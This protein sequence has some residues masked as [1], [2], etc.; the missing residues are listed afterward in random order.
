MTNKI[1]SILKAELYWYATHRPDLDFS[2]AIQ[3]AS[4]GEL[5]DEIQNHCPGQ[6]SSSETP[7]NNPKDSLASD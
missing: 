2:L 6:A 7:D 5:F 1:N 3:N 4:A